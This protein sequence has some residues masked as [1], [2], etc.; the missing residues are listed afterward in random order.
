[1][2]MRSSQTGYCFAVDGIASAGREGDILWW[3]WT[4][5]GL[6][7]VLPEP[8]ISE[9]LRLCKDWFGLPESTVPRTRPDWKVEGEGA[10]TAF[11]SMISS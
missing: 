9:E 11:I 3:R 4:Q 1:M 7:N 2:I 6:V 10:G 8:L 5:C